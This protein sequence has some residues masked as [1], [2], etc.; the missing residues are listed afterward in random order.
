MRALE[1]DYAIEAVSR[2]LRAVE[3]LAQANDGL[4]AGELARA[5]GLP[6]NTAFRLL[7]T[8]EKH[9]YVR[10]DPGSKK[11]LLGIRLFELGN[12]VFRSTDLSVLA[13]PVLQALLERFQE[14]VN[15]AVLHDDSLVYI[16]RLES[17]RSLRTSSAIG[18]RVPLHSTAL[19]KAILA[20]LPDAQLAGLIGKERLPALTSKTITDP[21]QLH[22]ELEFVRQRGYALDHE[23]SV[24]G[25]CC[26]GAPIFDRSGSVAAAVSISGPLQRLKDSAKREE[27]GQAL[28]QAA[29]DVSR[30]IGYIAPEESQFPPPTGSCP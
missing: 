24:E 7:Y 13:R 23:E 30:R 2:A 5:L 28:V 16:M 27:V 11:Y 14:T 8:L 29:H 4:G 22:R 3:A 19:G 26:L 18:G 6:R 15:M 21:R 17:S 9:G 10:Q 12:A 1:R 25:V 20:F